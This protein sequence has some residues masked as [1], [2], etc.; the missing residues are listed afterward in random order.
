MA[1]FNVN[2]IRGALTQGGA[3][4]TLFQVRI[5]NPITALAD[6]TSPFLIRA[7]TIPASDLGTIQI[8]FFGRKYKVAG[9]RTFAPWQVQVI[10]DEN[11]RV[12][13][14]MELWSYR[15]NGH[16]NNSSTVPGGVSPN[17]YKSIAEVIQFGKDGSILRVYRLHGLYPETINTIDLDWN[18]TDQIEEFSITFQYD[19]YDVVSGVTGFLTESGTYNENIN[20]R[21]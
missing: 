2:Q 19:Y 13:H 9:D 15:I 11:F 3:R 5:T 17:N 8:P 14:A 18:A 6:L 4:P 1:S 12:R 21:V 20:I 7:T 10:N 16:E